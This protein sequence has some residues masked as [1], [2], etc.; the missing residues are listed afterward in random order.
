MSTARF[1]CG[2]LFRSGPLNTLAVDSGFPAASFALSANRG[3]GYRS[4]PN[5]TRITKILSSPVRSSWTYWPFATRWTFPFA[6]PCSL[7]WRPAW[8]AAS[9][10]F[11]SGL[12]KSSPVPFAK[13]VALG[14]P[15][16]R[17]RHWPRPRTRTAPP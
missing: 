9:Y 17:T 5:S 10:R 11:A 4:L 2:M 16:I 7:A 1:G 8:S 15:S 3:F 6:L 12:R 14:T 13:L